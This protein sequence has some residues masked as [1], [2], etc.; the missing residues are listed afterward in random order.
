VPVHVVSKQTTAP[1]TTVG[2]KTASCTLT[3]GTDTS[4]QVTFTSVGGTQTAGIAYC[5]INFN[6]AYGAA[7]IVVLTPADALTA[8]I[9]VASAFYATST[10]NGFAINANTTAP[11]SSTTYTYY[12]HVIE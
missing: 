2:T 9:A 3:N 6:A 10:V 5:T 11:A 4:G 12:Y 7:P 1:T 8:R